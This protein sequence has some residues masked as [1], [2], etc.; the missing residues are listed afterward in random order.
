MV[1]QGKIPEET[2]AFVRIARKYRGMKQ[3]EIME[4]CGVSRSTVY[5]ILK[6]EKTVQRSRVPDKTK[7]AGRPRK[8]STRQE[9]LLLRHITTLRE[10]DGNFTVKRLMESAGLKTRDVSCRTVQRFLHSNGYRYLNS[11]KKGVLLNTDFKRRVQ[12]A[13]AMRKDYNENVWTEKIAFYLD[14]VSF[15]HKY[16]PCDQA[17]APKGKIWRKPHEGLARGCTAKGAH[18]GSGGRVAKFFVAI[19]YGKGVILCEQYNSF[20]GRYFKTLIERKFQRM[21]RESQKASRLFIQDGDPSQNCALARAALKRVG[22]K[23]LAIP[24]RSPDLNPIENIFNIVKRILE[25]DAIKKNISYETYEQFS[26]RIVE[27]FR[28]LDHT[29]IDST[30]ASMNKRID[31]IIGNKGSRTKY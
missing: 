18:C 3:N 25:A 6:G 19:S 20:N 2:R 11:R 30:I 14:G 17:R 23:L 31:A 16:N 28:K 1:F 7:L 26:A 27:T 4:R 21:F 15:I 29:L 5:R 12:F 22:A 13:K 8:L 9:R 10:E 24:P